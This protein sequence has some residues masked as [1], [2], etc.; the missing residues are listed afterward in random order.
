MSI[1]LGKV[2]ERANKDVI[3]LHISFFFS[4]FAV[5]KQTQKD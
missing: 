1:N 3:F 2:K 4:T 5:Q